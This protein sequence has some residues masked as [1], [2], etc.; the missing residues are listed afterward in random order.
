MKQTLYFLV[1]LFGFQV[2]HAQTFTDRCGT[3]EIHQHYLQ[4]PSYKNFHEQLE[5][6]TASYVQQQ[7]AAKRTRATLYKIP[8]VVH[9][10]HNGESVGSGAN[11]SVA[12]I[13]SQIAVL[14][15]DFRLLNTD[16]LLPSNGFWPYTDDCEIEFCLATLAPNGL[17]TSGIDRFNYGQSTYDYA[18]IEGII[19]PNTIWDRNKYLNIW[20]CKFG[21]TASTLLG[22]ATPP[23]APV[24]EDGVVIGTTNFGTTGNVASPYNKGR[25]ATHE[26]G[27]FFNLRHIWGDAF[28]G[29][30]FVADTAPAE[31]ANYGCKSYPYNANNSC[32]GDAK[33]EM[34]MN[35]MDYTDDACMRMFTNGQKNRMRAVLNPGGARASL[36][37]S[38]GCTWPTKLDE[39]ASETKSAIHLFPNPCTNHFYVKSDGAVGNHVDIKVFNALG[40]ELTSLL[41]IIKEDN[42]KLYIN[43]TKLQTG[44]FILKI[45]TDKLIDSKPFTIVK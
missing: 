6:Y 9:I 45:Q 42:D 33:G 2:I 1:L 31:E 16:S 30:D 39:I 36:T 14:N 37:S 35:Y 4:N 40:Q 28:C 20:V 15:K 34:Y 5:T 11:I 19:K 8:V 7:G 17:F 25:T 12:Q 32:G 3:E 38:N 21:G 18:D 13:N 10:I 26:I 43:T 23:G 29:T 27:H 22:F 41:S 24:D 44:T